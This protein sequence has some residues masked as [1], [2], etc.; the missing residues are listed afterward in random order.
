M[1][2]NRTILIIAIVTFVIGL[3][4]GYGMTGDGKEGKA[5]VKE[6]LAGVIQDI[7]AMEQENK[8]LRADL[9]KVKRAKAT[10]ENKEL[11]EKIAGMQKENEGLQAELSKLSGKVA[12]GE[13]QIEAKEELKAVIE[14]QNERIA[15]LEK[16]NKDLTVIVDTI[17]T[18]TMQHD[19]DAPDQPAVGTVEQPVEEVLEQAAEP[20][21]EQA[22]EDVVE[23]ETA[24]AGAEEHTN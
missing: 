3:I 9:E 15:E 19:I 11:K 8:D 18:L 12:H 21:Q 17:N 1:D 23:H 22:Q 24:P 5:D 2:N 6:V 4:I 14:S 20:V 7:E 10:R 16:E 13:L